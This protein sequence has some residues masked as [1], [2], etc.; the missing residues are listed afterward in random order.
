MWIIFMTTEDNLH[1]QLLPRAVAPLLEV[2]LRTMR[3]VVI[4]GPR[5]AGKSTL[6]RNH[7]QLASRPYFSLDD[8]AT[9]LRAQA[10]RDAFLRSTPEMIIDEVQRDPPLI[11]AIKVA[12]DRQRPHRREDGQQRRS[13]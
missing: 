12:V 10:D 1:D 7:P 5:Q 13:K 6:A 11:L 2:A 3:V 9:L 4:T 8:A